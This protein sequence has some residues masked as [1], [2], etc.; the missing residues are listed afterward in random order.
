MYPVT[1]TIKLLENSD[2]YYTIIVG[3]DGTYAY[4]SPNYNRNFYFL[5]NSLRGRRLSSIVHPDDLSLCMDV[6]AQCYQK[7][8]RHFPV[9]LRK[10][11]SKG[12]T[13]FTQWEFKAF[14]D[15]EDAPLGIFCLGHN[16]T[17]HVETH[18]QL[19]SAKAEIAYKTDQ[20]KQISFLQSHGIRK[21]LANIMGL[22]D[23]ISS[24]YD[25]DNLDNIHQMLMES[26][27][28]LDQVIKTI[29]DG[30]E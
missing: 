21:P 23:I 25:E 1:E 19:T 27:C 6:A 22:T 2:S 10:I 30:I 18:S 24:K 28:E 20:L 17:D 12:D 26:A 5:N 29:V 14:F 9:V 4:V 11:N 7:P 15:K 3:T 16:I 13:I 8:G